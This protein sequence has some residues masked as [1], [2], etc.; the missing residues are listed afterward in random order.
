MRAPGTSRF[1]GGTP[2]DSIPSFYSIP[3]IRPAAMSLRV[4][5]RSTAFVALAVIILGGL[6]TLPGLTY[7]QQSVG[8]E[9]VGTAPAPP[10]STESSFEVRLPDADPPAAGGSSSEALA[11]ALTTGGTVTNRTG[12]SITSWGLVWTV[13]GGSVIDGRPLGPPRDLAPG[14]H[15]LSALVT[16]EQLGR[17]FESIAM[18]LSD[19]PSSVMSSGVTSMSIGSIPGPQAQQAMAN[20]SAPPAFTERLQLSPSQVAFIFLAAP[21]DLGA[22]ATFTYTPAVVMLDVP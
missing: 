10:D 12:E 19:D 1:T 22:I 20:A 18:T 14:E 11:A 6:A 7:A 16:P 2:L 4:V 21:A 3:F 13:R 9:N 5:H 8:A 17:F 15:R